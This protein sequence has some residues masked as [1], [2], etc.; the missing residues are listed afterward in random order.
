MYSQEE[1]Q[2]LVARSKE[3]LSN[4]FKEDAISAFDFAE[5][6]RA[7][8]RYHEWR[9]YIINDP[10][11]SDFEYDLLYKKLEKLEK[12]NADLITPD[13]PTQ[14]VSLD[15]ANDFPVVKHL[16]PMLS[17]A[18]S[19]DEADLKEF[20][21]QVKKLLELDPES[22][23]EYCAEPKFDGGSI[24]LVYEN[25]HFVR[26]AT[27]GDGS[28]GEDI[29]NNM[30]SLRSLPIKAEFSKYG[31][32]KVEIRGEA[33]I[34]KDRFE[35]INKQREDDGLSLFANPRNAATGGLRMKDPNETGARGLE[36]FLYQ[37]AYVENVNGRDK[38]ESV[39]THDQSISLLS[40]L[41]FKVPD[42]ERKVCK[43]IKEV[44][45]F[46]HEWQDKRDNYAYEIDGI[47][48][49]VNNREQ[50]E[51]CGFT[52]H[53]PRWA[54]AFKFKA[55]QATSILLNVEYQ[56]GK[57]GA[58]TPVAKIEPV[59]LAGV[60][61]SSISLH[62]EDFIVSRD[63][64]IGDMVLV[65]RAGDVIPYIVKSLTELRTGNE[66]T[67]EYPTNCPSCNTKL[68]RLEGEAAWRCPNDLCPAKVLQ[69]LIFHASKDAM[70][71][72]GMGESNIK[73]FHELGWINDFADIYNLDYEAIANLEGFGKKSADKLKLA[74]EKAKSNPLHR[75][76]HSLSIHHLGKTA[77]KLIAER[78]DSIWDL[79]K[80]QREQYLEI[81]GIGG[82]VADNV[83]E[84]FNNSLNVDI[85]RR[86]ESYGV[87]LQ[88]LTEDK[89]L[90]LKEGLALSGKSILFTGTLMTM[91]RKEAE[92]MAEDSGAK[93]LSSVSS[94]L[95]ILVVGEN[96]G[97]KKAKA[98]KIGSIQILTEEEFLNIIGKS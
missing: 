10:L 42:K 23:V 6:L 16:T 71:I 98:E 14:R 47:V 17:L 85:I 9:Y 79:L 69:K 92:K 93:N 62:N 2:K 26:G 56:V 48:V 83:I 28:V 31:V 53:H 44:V 19:Y 72:E 84:Y 51:Q 49:K 13:S 60:T 41:G 58:V 40:N 57:I 90:I 67:I 55:K 52:S 94:N 80:W 35:K 81:K 86:M 22:N 45:E 88:A 91:G 73:R 18:N 3:I 32:K 5:Q 25:D 1:Q 20:D 89:P 24:A 33:L 74:V 95:D 75:V 65:E 8:I 87:N 50:Q 61:V 27:R 15:I 21:N 12:G 70:D 4:S 82:V 63:I 68:V 43:N 96:A 66:K 97:S 30:K 78:I 54:I 7:L 59:Q 29:T 77:S 76:L 39:K 38:I 36:A 37:I 11:V 46:C 64:K 34:R